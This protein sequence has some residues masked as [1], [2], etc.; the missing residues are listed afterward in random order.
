MQ[1]VS[2]CDKEI[3]EIVAQIRRKYD[4]KLEEIEAEYLPKKKELDM[5][6]RKV[7]MNKM[8]AE[9]FKSKWSDIRASGAN[10]IQQG[11]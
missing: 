11:A 7:L 5:S 10:G 2:D 6:H 1:L 3:E 4:L 9:A 8:L